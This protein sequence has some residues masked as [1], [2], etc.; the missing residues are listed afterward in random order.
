M[1]LCRQVRSRSSWSHSIARSVFA[2]PR[3][4][5]RLCRHHLCRIR[6]DPRHHPPS[7]QETARVHVD[8][9][10]RHAASS[11]DQ[12]FLTTNVSTPCHSATLGVSGVS[13]VSSAA[14]SFF[15]CL[16]LESLEVGS[17]AL[18]GFIPGASRSFLS[19]HLKSAPISNY[20]GARYRKVGSKQALTFDRL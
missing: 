14:S 3:R 11:S 19:T 6:Q 2:C 12:P 5:G 17:M 16:L 15:F 10:A 4:P 18:A 1:A 7:L 9:S 20:L 8:D 13:G